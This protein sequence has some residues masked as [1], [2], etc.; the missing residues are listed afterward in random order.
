MA[1]EAM[2]R[3]CANTGTTLRQLKKM[4][5]TLKNIKLNYFEKDEYPILGDYNNGY[6]L[7]QNDNLKVVAI[8]KNNFEIIESKENIDLEKD[9]LDTGRRLPRI[10]L[11]KNR[12]ILPNKYWEIGGSE[13]FERIK[14]AKGLKKLGLNLNSF[15]NQILEND[16][17]RI[18]LFQ[19][20]LNWLEKFSFLLSDQYNPTFIDCIFLRKVEENQFTKRFKQ[21]FEGQIRQEDLNSNWN[22]RIEINNLADHISECIS[23][24]FEW[25]KMMTDFK[26]VFE[27]RKFEFQRLNELILLNFITLIE[28]WEFNCFELKYSYAK[29]CDCRRIVI[30]EENG[31]VLILTFDNIIH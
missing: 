15:E 18:E 29:G 30:E 17:L 9:E 14:T 6:Y 11:K 21:L 20:S 23:W 31:K 4:K 10:W 8:E 22:Q 24:H 25:L 28:D 2:R 3:Y 1:I 7:T 19:E 5:I 16:Q 26:E 12:E 13:L 27:Q